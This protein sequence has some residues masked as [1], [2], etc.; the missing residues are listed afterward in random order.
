VLD[1]SELDARRYATAAEA[2][3]GHE[4]LVNK[5]MT[6]QTFNEIVGDG[7]GVR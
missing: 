1:W 5:Y 3:C 7:T 6:L 2:Q 4:E